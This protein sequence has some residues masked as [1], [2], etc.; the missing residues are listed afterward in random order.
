MA[1]IV[2]VVLVAILAVLL[3]VPAGSSEHSGRESSPIAFGPTGF[4]QPSHRWPGE[5]ALPLAG[6]PSFP[7]LFNA[8]GLPAGANWTVAIGGQNVSSTTQN[9]TVWLANGTYAYSITAP[10]GYAVGH[11]A[12]S[13]TVDGPPTDVL[14][15]LDNANFY[16]IQGV[17]TDPLNDRLYLPN[18]T[19][20]RLFIV[21]G[22]TGT[23]IANVSTGSFPLTPVLGADGDFVFV[24]NE[25]ASTVTVLNT[26]SDSVA[27]TLR[28]GGSPYGAT[29]DPATGLL[30]VPNSAGSNVSVVNTSSDKVVASIATNNTPTTVIDITGH[31]EIYVL[32][33]ATTP[34]AVDVVNT[35]TDTVT[36]RFYISSYELWGGVYL[37][38][39][40]QVF[41]DDY[42]NS[43]VL[44]YDLSS[45]TPVATISTPGVYAPELPVWDP[46][47]GLIYLTS[48]GESSAGIIDPATERF[49]ENLS[50][51]GHPSQITLDPINGDLWVPLF[52]DQ[53]LE[54]LDGNPQTI[55]VAFQ[56]LPSTYS[57]GFEEA[58]LP[59][60]SSWTVTFD[61]A[62]H[63][64]E[65]A[66]VSFMATNGS[67]SYS[68]ARVG[69][70]LPTP[71][72]GTLR[73]NGSNLSQPV[74]FAVPPLPAFPVTFTT[75]GL[76]VGAAWTLMINRSSFPTTAFELVVNLTNGSY[77]FTVI[78]PGGYRAS[79]AGGWANVSGQAV[80]EPVYFSKVMVATYAVDFVESGLPTNAAWSVVVNGS[81][82]TGSTPRLMKDLANGTYAFLVPSPT[83]YSP[84]PT[85][86][87]VAVSGAAKTVTIVFSPATPPAYRVTLVENGL[88]AGTNWSVTVEGVT[89]WSTSNQTTFEEGNGS[90]RYVAE[91]AGGVSASPNSTSFTVAGRATQV[92]VW[93]LT[94]AT[95]AAGA[96]SA[97]LFGLPA[98]AVYVG[99]LVAVGCG[100]IALVYLRRRSGARRRGGPGTHAREP[101]SAEGPDGPADSGPS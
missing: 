76:P 65:T 6:T 2:A 49:V 30:Y 33:D 50:L 88:S 86:G 10:A 42:H 39:F 59:T 15:S 73:V 54:L 94:A 62:A 52:W 77:A 43:R 90:Y 3:T 9:L 18:D 92:E 13:L 83:G 95:T 55:D 47:N 64:S 71:A 93:F 48:T 36:D 4:A 28:V 51:A 101:E 74:S 38:Q 44:V 84:E 78:A 12:G 24:P 21:N 97:E 87:T 22:A 5:R 1:K 79:P 89:Q 7:V 23:E 56:L 20:N 99:V 32:C 11:P 63:T 61:G 96:T 81:T 98:L 67:Y 29:L 37:P 31:E 68:I 100:A 46:R 8:S 34:A 75:V 69:S 58:G 85:S 60:G 66:Q 25:Q 27:A 26:S 72:A 82:W 17:L 41:I 57:I 91:A 35:S 53:E 40:Q 80:F 45:T 70:Y 14:Q 16:T 19:S